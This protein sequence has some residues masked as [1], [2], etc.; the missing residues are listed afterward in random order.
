MS[1]IAGLIGKWKCSE[2][3]GSLN[4]RLNI[5][6]SLILVRLRKPWKGHSLYTATSTASD[7]A[8][9]LQEVRKA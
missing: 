8:Y 4:L 2:I 5:T 1:N 7:A 6:L 3:N 9:G